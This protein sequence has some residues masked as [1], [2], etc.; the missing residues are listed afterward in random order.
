MNHTPEQIKLM[1]G[2]SSF[3]AVLGDIISSRAYDCVCL[4]RRQPFYRHRLKQLTERLEKQRRAYEK[5]QAREILSLQDFANANQEV[6]DQCEQSFLQMESAI[7]IAIGKTD[8][9]A[10]IITALLTCMFYAEAVFNVRNSM[11]ECMC[12]YKINATGF[13]SEPSTLLAPVRNL[14]LYYIGSREEVR[15]IAHHPT[16]QNAIQVLMEKLIT[17]VLTA[18]VK[19]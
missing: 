17:D 9:D 12:R 2:C 3:A 8:L 19:Q 1:N 14:A 5:K 13:R 4:L 7:K 10:G 15:R 18:F 16:V 6:E 11:I